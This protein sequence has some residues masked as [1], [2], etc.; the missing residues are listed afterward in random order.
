MSQ[1]LVNGE[2]HASTTPLK[3]HPAARF[4]DEYAGDPVD[5]VWCR[6]GWAGILTAEGNLGRAAPVPSGRKARRTLTVVVQ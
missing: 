4:V 3:S 1:H 5:S 6:L 2:A